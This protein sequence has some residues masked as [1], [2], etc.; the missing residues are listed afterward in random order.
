MWNEKYS[1]GS[2]ENLKEK[3]HLGKILS[4]WG[5]WVDSTSG[6]LLPNL[7]T[8][9]YF[10]NMKVSGDWEKRGESGAERRLGEGWDDQNSE[11]LGQ[12][13]CRP[14]RRSPLLLGDPEQWSQIHRVCGN[15]PSFFFQALKYLQDVLG[16]KKGNGVISHYPVNHSHALYTSLFRALVSHLGRVESWRWWWTPMTPRTLV[17]IELG[18]KG[19]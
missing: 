10:L 12:L 3:G 17:I 13:G 9:T 5:H 16:I 1:T 8:K 4:P 14:Q 15:A 2:F 19:L 18:F 7:I 6:W 11:Q